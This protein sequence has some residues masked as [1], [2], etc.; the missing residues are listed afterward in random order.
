MS[1]QPKRLKPLPVTLR[2]LYLR[3]GNFCAFPSC[4][5][6]M[7]NTKGVFVGQ[8][9]HIEAAEKGG[10]RFN[11]KMTN[12]TRRAAANL[13]MMCYDHHKETDDVKAFTVAV[14]RKMKVDH[15]KRFTD[16][17]FAI[18]EQ[19]TDWTSLTEPQPAKNL[20]RMRDVLGWPQSNEELDREV[21]TLAAHANH[22]RD[23][24]IEVRRFLGAVAERIVKVSH[25]GA[26][27]HHQLTNGASI[28]VSDLRGAWQKGEKHI[29]DRAGELQAYRLGGPDV[30][31][32]D[33]G[34]RPAVRVG[35]VEG[36][37]IWVDLAT[38]AAKERVAMRSFTDDLDFSS[39]DQSNGK[40]TK[41]RR[42]RR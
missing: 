18:L 9:C 38:F 17:E 11:P 16:V 26:V 13:M 40:E 24:P 23:V 31:H 29:F 19:L 8:I 4:Q 36:W 27:L 6:R 42:S 21:A 35:N 25:T 7:L 28:L 20:R 2:E 30:I 39:L 41:R 33:L 34:D 37:T 10:P 22:L 15:E 1:E 12:D 3:S 32:T 5:R 14:L